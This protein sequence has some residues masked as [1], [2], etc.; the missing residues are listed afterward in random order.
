MAPEQIEGQEADARAGIFAFGAVLYEMVTGKKA[1]EGK[2][3][4]S[5]IAA[6]MHVDPPAPS[7][8]QPVTPS[9]VDRLIR[10]CLAKDAD[11]R[12]QTAHDL[13]DELRWIAEHKSEPVGAA[14]VTPRRSRRLGFE[15]GH[16][17]GADRHRGDRLFG[18]TTAETES[19][20]IHRA[21][22]GGRLIG[23]CCATRALAR[24]APHRLC[25]SR[26]RTKH[27]RPSL[28]RQRGS[29]PAPGDGRGLQPVLVSAPTALFQTGTFGTA[30]TSHFTAT[31][32]GRRF[33]VRAPGEADAAPIT[34]VLNW[35]ST[36]KK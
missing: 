21:T 14:S 22:P 15:Y 7:V 12:W 36:L 1:F 3:Q 20:P 18:R 34:V 16:G 27:P 25:R 8:L 19:Y 31:P 4:A 9:S 2:S 30:V 29:A 10:K 24:R 5:L 6:I 35:S 17:R 33:L 11:D 13:H 23:G 28:D 32:D 26:R